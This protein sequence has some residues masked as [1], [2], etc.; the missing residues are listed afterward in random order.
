[1]TTSVDV[2]GM[3]LAQQDFQ[4]ALDAINTVYAS[5]TTERDNLAAN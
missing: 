3:I 2:Q 1:M 4:E 5:M